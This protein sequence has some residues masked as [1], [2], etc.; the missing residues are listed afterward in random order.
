MLR[1]KY[2]EKTEQHMKFVAS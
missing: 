2:S 1:E